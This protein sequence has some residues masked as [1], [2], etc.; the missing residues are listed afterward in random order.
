MPYAKFLKDIFIGKRT[1]DVAETVSL[2]ENCSAINKM[3]PKLKDPEN[4]S[5]PCAIYKMLIDNS[6]CD[7]GVSVSLMLYSVNQRLELGKLFPTNITLQLIDRSIKF[8]KGKVEDV[9]L[10]VGKFVI[11]IDFVVLE[12]DED[13]NILIIFGR[14]FFATSGAMIDVKTAK[15][16]F[17]VGEEDIEF[18]LNES[19]KYLSSSLENCMRVEILDNIMN[20]MHEHLLK[21]NDP[22]E[23]VLLTKEKIGEHGKEMAFFD[24]IINESME[25]GDD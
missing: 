11:P 5:I 9:P 4:V 1:C 21:P 23:C 14:P 17:K 18:D 10:R 16:S 2:T 6:L 19:M 7:L 3:P 8:P 12:M 22:L 13:F 24:R 15:T 20:S 25:E